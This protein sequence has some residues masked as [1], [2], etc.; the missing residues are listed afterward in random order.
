MFT[1]AKRLMLF[2]L[3]FSAMVFLTTAQVGGQQLVYEGSPLYGTGM[4]STEVMGDLLYGT[5]GPLQIFSFVN[6]DSLVLIGGYP[7]LR[8]N[9]LRVSGSYVYATDGPP[10]MPGYFKVLDISD[11]WRPSLVSSIDFPWSGDVAVSG[12]YAYIE[13]AGGTVIM[14]VADPAA[15]YRVGFMDTISGHMLIS[16]SYLFIHSRPGICIFDISDPGSP[17]LLSVYD[18]NE[19]HELFVQGSYLYCASSSLEIVDITDPSSPSFLGRTMALGDIYG[20]QVAGAYAYVIIEP[21]DDPSR[22]VAID[23]SDPTAPIQV[24]EYSEWGN[25]E[26]LNIVGQRA[27]VCGS[28]AAIKIFDIQDPANPTP[29]WDYYEPHYIAR[30]YRYDNLVFVP[31]RE[32]GLWI[33]DVSDDNHPEMLCRFATPGGGPMSVATHDQYALVGDAFNGLLILD[34]TNPQSPDSVGF[35][36]VQ[37]PWSIYVQ[38]NYAYVAEIWEGLFIIDISNPSAPSLVGTYNAAGYDTDVYV[39]GG[40][41]Y[42]STLSPGGLCVIDVSDPSHPTPVGNCPLPG[43]TENLFIQGAYAFLADGRSGLEIVNIEN[44]SSPTLA[45]NLDTENYAFDV[46]VLGNTAFVIDDSSGVLAVNVTDPTQPRL[47]TT[48]D[49][50][51]ISRAVALDSN[52]LFVADER[53]LLILR[54]DQADAIEEE[55]DL[56]D[57]PA[58]L[59]NY[60]NPFNSSTLISY[61][62]DISGEIRMYDISGQLA[63]VLRIESGSGGQ[64]TWDGTNQRGKRLSSGVYFARAKSR[65]GFETIK[66]VLLK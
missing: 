26:A 50:P 40:H 25:Y 19:G 56:P 49:T 62:D 24:G 30:V 18:T 14:D 22:F 37:R 2:Q 65:S 53:S 15:P 6:P 45:G 48:F 55:D 47:L 38:G 31:A 9:G 17:A 20:L 21:W 5:N 64:V 41:A 11:P 58:F 13:E 4:A 27:Y 8:A 46:A 12:D 33:F 66:M 54:Y 10:F 42:V 36:P 35:Y 32:D 1:M 28:Y 29:T 3:L 39:R 57:R 60:P 52:Y 34:I 59:S 43:E 16:G 51:G 63:R 61:S 7:F 44:P 23:V